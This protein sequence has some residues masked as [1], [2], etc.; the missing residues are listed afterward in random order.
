MSGRDEP[1]GKQKGGFWDNLPKVHESRRYVEP[2]K[3]RDLMGSE[4]A[5]VQHPS[6]PTFRTEIICVC[7]RERERERER[8]KE[9]KREEKRECAHR[10]E[11]SPSRASLPLAEPMKVGEV[12]N[13]RDEKGAR[14]KAQLTD[15]SNDHENAAWVTD[16]LDAKTEQTVPDGWE[17]LTTDQG[18]V[19]YRCA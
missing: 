6:T 11:F 4:H 8:W 19:F 10:V 18:R 2:Y 5:P 15:N 1:E 14:Q 16:F 17:Q 9:E 13:E 3:K 7:V 12:T